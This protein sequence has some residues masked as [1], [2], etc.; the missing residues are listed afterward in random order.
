MPLYLLLPLESFFENFLFLRWREEASPRLSFF[1]RSLVQPLK[2][3]FRAD[4][5]FLFFLELY[6]L[7]W[8]RLLFW[9]ILYHRFIKEPILQRLYKRGWRFLR[10]LE[11]LELELTLDGWGPFL[12][13]IFRPVTRPVGRFYYRLSQ[14][15][16]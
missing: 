13:R 5:G 2:S 3:F 16:K 1:Y 8:H 12:R 14:R 9:Q 11:I 4:G 15:L 7:D 6:A 10:S